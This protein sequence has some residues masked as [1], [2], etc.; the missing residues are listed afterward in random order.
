MVIG[1]ILICI[2]C[3]IMHQIMVTKGN[4]YLERSSPRYN[5]ETKD[6]TGEMRD[7]VGTVQGVVSAVS[8]DKFY[9]TLADGHLQQVLSG[10]VPLPKV[11]D[12]IRLTYAGGEPPKALLIE[13]ALESLT[14]NS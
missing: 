12:T 1:F 13:P 5:L 9:L 6:T 8:Y 3:G 2:C 7:G 14:E 11:G 4:L 10:D